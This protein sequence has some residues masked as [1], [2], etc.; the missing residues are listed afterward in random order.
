MKQFNNK[1]RIETANNVSRLVSYNT[2]VAIYDHKNN[3]MQVLGW[4]SQTTAKHINAFLEYFGFDK[5]S[6]QEMINYQN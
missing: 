6:K 5:C 1:A 4:Y 3:K 2:E